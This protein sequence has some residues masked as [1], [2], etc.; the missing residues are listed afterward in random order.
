MNAERRHRSLWRHADFMKLW[1]AETIS[2]LGTQVTLLA[3]P[4]TAILILKASPF[5]VGLLGTL[6]F[7]PFIVVGLPAGVWVDRLRR[8]PILIVGDLG[9]VIALGSV[10]IAYE[11]GVLHIVQLYIVAFVTGVLTVFFDVSYQSYLPSLVGREHLVDGNAKLEISRSGAQLA[12]PGVAGALIQALKAPVAILVDA[13]SYLGSAIFIFLIRR[14]EPPVVVHRPDGTKP[15]MRTEI[16]EGVRYVWRHPLLR[17]IAFCTGSSN[18]FSQVGT[19]VVLI[20][21]VRRLGLS[22]GKIGLIFAVGNVGILLGAFLAPRVAKRLGI[23]PTIVGSAML[24]GLAWVPIALL[25]KEVA[26]PV[27]VLALFIAGLGGT[28]YNINQ[29]SLRQSITPDRIQGRMN[30]TMRFMVWGTIPIGSF[31]GGIL[32]GTIGLRPTLWV[33]AIGSLLSFI[34]PFFSPVRTLERIPEMPAEAPGVAAAL[35]SSGDGL[36][37]PGEFPHPSDAYTSSSRPNPG[38][39]PKE[40]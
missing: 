26:F 31:V 8:R 29:V 12:G 40:G 37:E 22:P 11:L 34:P 14:K 38:H 1:T 24:F 36:V 5:Q 18:F 6:E 3:L 20:F 25:T 7:L 35:S 15:R 17:P 33:A 10:P 2:Q 30:A 19:A 21:A 32:G 28:V 27:W 16:A 4:L 23:G 13:I 9:R 39:D